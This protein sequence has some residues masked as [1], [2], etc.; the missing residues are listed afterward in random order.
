M[1]IKI[2][3]E[4]NVKALVKLN[5]QGHLACHWFS[6]VSEDSIFYHREDVDAFWML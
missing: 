1:K 2:P 4:P 3:V 5:V 6:M